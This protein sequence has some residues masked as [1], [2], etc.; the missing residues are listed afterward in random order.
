MGYIEIEKNN[1][2]LCFWM[3][4][5]QEVK[6]LQI[7][8]AGPEQA[9]TDIEKGKGRKE[10][11]EKGKAD[12]KSAGRIVEILVPG[13]KTSPSEAPSDIMMCHR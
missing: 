5:G 8:A 10:S 6:L 1:M 12:R 7:K 9:E 4:Q 11:T 13:E 2:Y 3:E